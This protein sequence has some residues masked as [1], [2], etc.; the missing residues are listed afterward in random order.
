MVIKS[1]RNQAEPSLTEINFKSE[2]LRENQLKPSWTLRFS[3]WWISAGRT[4]IVNCRLIVGQTQSQRSLIDRKSGPNTVL[5]NLS[6]KL[7]FVDMIETVF[8]DFSATSS[9]N[10]GKPWNQLLT[11]TSY[12]SWPDLFN[13]FVWVWLQ[14]CISHVF[15]LRLQT[16]WLQTRSC[17]EAAPNFMSMAV[18]FILFSVL[19]VEVDE[20]GYKILLKHS[21]TRYQI[22]IQDTEATWWE[23][24]K[25]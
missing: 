9:T 10:S 18:S 20:L 12:F 1:L 8:N 11:L 22:Q 19:K 23:R 6:V 17:L 24:N 5:L 16:V 4:L 21:P 13:G 15:V 7:E 14:S 3:G 25:P 2:N